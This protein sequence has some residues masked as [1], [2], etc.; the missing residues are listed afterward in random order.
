MKTGGKQKMQDVSFK[1]VAEFLDFLPDDELKM[2][3]LLRHAIFI[4][5]PTVSE[6]LAYNVPFYKHHRNFCFIWP[7]SILWGNKKSYEGVRFGFT[8]GYL[9]SDEV[10][11]LD[12]GERKQVYWKDYKKITDIDIEL[13]RSYIFE[14]IL[15]DEQL[16][17]NK[18]GI[19]RKTRR[20]G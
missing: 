2:T 12:R 15:V 14:A 16:K 17:D 1:N 11:Y 7:A 8:N 20:P 19:Q 6:K 4:C 3:E 18:H 9:L 10:K 13:L 5:L